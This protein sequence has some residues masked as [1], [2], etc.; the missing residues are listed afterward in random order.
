MIFEP[1]TITDTVLI[2]PTI[3]KDSR[4]AFC[5]TFRQDQ[6]A[7][8]VGEN[9]KF[10]QDNQS[11]SNAPYTLRGLHMQKSPF[12]QGKLVRCIQGR[13]FDVAVDVRAG[14]PSFKHWVGVVLEPETCEHLWI[15]AGFL[16]GFLTL[17]PDSI[18]QYKCTDFYQPDHE[19]N[20]RWDDPDLAIDWPLVELPVVL[21]DADRDAGGFVAQIGDGV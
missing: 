19:I 7:Q 3:H 11:V 21:S 20:V 17:E 12:A 4:G 2:K 1:T 18:V 5:E 9:V 15:P 6:F 16:H 8:A 13:I 14:S 10:V